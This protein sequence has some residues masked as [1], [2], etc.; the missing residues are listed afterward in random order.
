ME[1]V[2]AERCRATDGKPCVSMYG[3]AGDGISDDSPGT[4]AGV[5]GEGGTAGNRSKS[6]ASFKKPWVFQRVVVACYLQLH[7]IWL[8][9]Y[10]ADVHRRLLGTLHKVSPVA[11]SG[12]ETRVEATAGGNSTKKKKYI[13]KEKT[14]LIFF[15]RI[16]HLFPI[17]ASSYSL[18]E[19][20]L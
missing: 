4:S 2:E 14:F 8:I 16:P 11:G 12:D 1:R 6:K 5:G 15:W 17:K 7:V 13:R 10:L 19:S 9:P 20:K 18:P 3:I